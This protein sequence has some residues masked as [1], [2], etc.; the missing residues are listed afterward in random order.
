[1]KKKK[2][3]IIGGAG[4][5]GLNLAK[6]FLANKFDVDIIDNFQRGK[7]DSDYNSVTSSK[8]V[9]VFKIDIS[10]KINK[11]IHNNYD[12]IYNLAAIVGVKNV[13]NSPFKVLLANVEIQKKSIEI[14]KKQKNLK[15]FVFTSTSEVYSGSLVNKLLKFP[16]EENNI[17]ALHEFKNPRATYMISKIYGE[18]MCHNSGLPFLILRPHNIY[19]PRM[20]MAHVIPELIFKIYNNKKNFL[21]IKNGKHK[22]TFCYVEDAIS[23]IFKL[24]LNPK[25]NFKTYNLGN[26]SP[27]ITMRSLAKIIL[28]IT[29]K[30][31]KMKIISDEQLNDFSPKRRRPNTAALRKIINIKNTLPLYEGIKKT[32]E[33]YKKNSNL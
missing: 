32:Y 29:N 25:T 11:K 6:K 28:S 31:K 2:V 21:K 15:K 10:S 3:L 9:R 22:R 17:I 33:W 14:A 23:M 18:I 24:S 4:F 19:G 16:T 8:N 20:G 30:Q 1:M 13:L 26:Q 5:L 12:Y 27:E 7:V